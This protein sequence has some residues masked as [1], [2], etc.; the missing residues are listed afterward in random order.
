MECDVLVVGMG[1]GGSTAARFAAAGGSDVIAIDKRAEIGTPI[2]CAEGVSKRIFEILE[3]GPEDRW[4]RKEVSGVKLVSPN[5][6]V[7][8]LDDGNV[9][10]VAYGYVLDR[11]V[12]DKD[13]VAIA[14]KEGVK[15]FLKT[16]FVTGERLEDGRVRAHAKHFGEDLTIDAKLII[17]A[18]G[19]GSRV[20][21]FFGIRTF[22]PLKYMES[23]VQYEMTNIKDIKGL[24]MYFGQD[25]APGGYVW[26]FP[27]SDESANVGIGIIP[28]MT[29]KNAKYY[30][31]RFLETPRMEGASFVEL[32][33]GGVPVSR[34]LKQ[35]YG[36]NI[37][38]VGDAGRLVNPITGGGISTAISTGKHAGQTASKAIREGKLDGESL[39]IYQEKWK[40]EF[41]KR[42]EFLFKAQEIFVDMSDKDLDDT[43]EALRKVNLEKISEM[44]IIK[45]IAK[46]NVK[47]LFKLKSLL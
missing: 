22:V 11:K 9:N 37:L 44:E 25:V 40:E 5:G 19:V 17:A 31:D 39:S 1:P 34:P 32:N 10:T 6:T 41:G 38:M 20:G 43:A 36:D 14:A 47:L 12:F 16:R 13:L 4:L 3:T 8:D 23:C 33:A 27:K 30:L 26:I 2:Q 45:A 18:D 7:V 24:E 15:V 46:T 35:T 28:T 42:I 29:D 21:P